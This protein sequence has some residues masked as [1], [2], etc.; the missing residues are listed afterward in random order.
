MSSTSRAAR[1]LGTPR[2][3]LVHAAQTDVGA[4][5][6]IVPIRGAAVVTV[7]M[8]VLI[9]LGYPQATVAAGIGAVFT[10]AGDQRG[11]V[12]ARAKGMGWTAICVSVAC[13]LGVLASDWWWV[14]LVATGAVAFVC[15]YAAKAGRRSALAGLLSLIVFIV[16]AGAPLALGVAVGDGLLMLMGGAIQLAIGILPQAIIRTGGVRGDICV[17]FRTVGHAIA[18][19]HLMTEAASPV[20]ALQSARGGVDRMHGHTQVQEQ[21]DALLDGLSD[22]RIGGVVLL[23]APLHV[24][25]PEQAAL[26][27]FRARAAELA[28]A[29]GHAVEVRWRQHGLAARA[30]RMDAAADACSAVSDPRARVAVDHMRTGLRQAMDAL[31]GGVLAGD[32]RSVPVDLSASRENISAL[33]GRTTFDDI[34]LRHALRLT[35]AELAATGLAIAMGFPHNYWIPMTVAWVLRPDLAGTAVR[36]TARIGGTILGLA[37]SALVLGIF[38]FGAV[39]VLAIVFIS[40]VAIY[41]FIGPNYALCTAG[42]TAFVIAVFGLLGDPLIETLELRLAGTLI[43]A[44]IAVL[45]VFAFPSR[46]TQALAGVLGSLADSVAAYARDVRTGMLGRDR[47]AARADVAAHRIAAAQMVD[48]A[49]NEF[50][51][52]ALDDDQARAVLTGLTR[53]TAI[54]A[55]SELE[56]GAGAADAVPASVVTDI[57]DVGRRL[58]ALQDTGS[59]PRREGPEPAVSPGAGDLM[60]SVEM[61]QGALDEAMGVRSAP[62][63]A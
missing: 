10:G 15:A 20:L 32:V 62:A 34:I 26:D 43:A 36:V 45:A 60:A 42:V 6:W 21:Y 53:A 55:A 51:P 56:G 41:A 9:A 22:L 27:E 29:I 61:A 5:R 40:S 31:G 46:T 52:H 25:P 48:A 16:Y 23:G 28:I 1:M 47:D 39:P 7:L 12:A 18:R 17:A 30:A 59:V 35:A 2:R 58:H 37:L 54:V 44:V 63:P 8:A 11:T 13:S 33:V 19:P 24:S 38:G 50:I 49:G 57:D 14:R 4:V 3:I